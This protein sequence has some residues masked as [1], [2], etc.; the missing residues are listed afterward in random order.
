MIQQKE[1]CIRQLHLISE[2]DPLQAYWFGRFV[3]FRE[4]KFLFMTPQ[5]EF[6]VC[7][8]RRVENIMLQPR[9]LSV[10]CELTVLCQYT[11]FQK[12]SMK[13]DT[14]DKHWET[15]IYTSFF[16]REPRTNSTLPRLWI[17]KQLTVLEQF[18]NRSNRQTFRNNKYHR[19]F[20][21]RSYNMPWTTNNIS[22]EWHYHFL[23]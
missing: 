6:R 18:V 21:N 7:S 22:N 12:Q 15:W 9:S 16:K 8:I 11:E 19:I 3:L 2:S 4:W 13:I 20:P 5:E 10:S 14:E 1:F 23:Q 17:S